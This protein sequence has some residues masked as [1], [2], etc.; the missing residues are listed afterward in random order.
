MIPKSLTAVL[1]GTA[2]A[3][4]AALVA[5]GPAAASPVSAHHLS[6]D[7]RAG[8]VFVQN[9]ALDGNQIVAYRRAADGGLTRL[10]QYDTGGLGGRLAGAA[11]DFTASQGALGYLPRHRELLAVNPGSDTLTV[12]GVE[13]T[14]LAR[15]QIVDTAGSFPVSVTAD[16]NRVFVLNARGG[17]SIQ[18]YAVRGGRLEPVAAWHREL[19]LPVTTGAAEFTHTPG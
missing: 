8:A 18:G 11:V 12:F 13:G 17:G 15:R 16:G 2:G 4:V 3:A 10:A 14:T 19:G 5:A 7:D 9:D 1:T 6:S